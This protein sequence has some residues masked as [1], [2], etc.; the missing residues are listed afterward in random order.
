MSAFPA[1]STSFSPNVSVC[2]NV[3]DI[4]CSKRSFGLFIATFLYVE[5]FFNF[6][7]FKV[8]LLNHCNFSICGNVFNI[9]CVKMIFLNSAT[10]LYVEKFST[11]CVF[12]MILLNQRQLFCMWKRVQHS[13][14]KTVVWIIFATFLC[15]ETFSAFRV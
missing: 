13:V 12:Y 10:F 7:S 2:G 1:H 6:L 9:L 15:V 11:F 3:F 5:Y 4:L 14:F 8:I